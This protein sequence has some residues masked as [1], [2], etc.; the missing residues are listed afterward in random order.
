MA[1]CFR[2]PSWALPA[3]TSCSSRRV[4]FHPFT[5]THALRTRAHPVAPWRQYVRHTDGDHSHSPPI[6]QL[7]RTVWVIFRDSTSRHLWNEGGWTLSPLTPW[8]WAN[9][10]HKAVQKRRIVGVVEVPGLYAASSKDTSMASRVQKPLKAD[11]SRVAISSWKDPLPPHT[12]KL[13]AQ[14]TG[15]RVLACRRRETHS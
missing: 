14:M 11:Q 3:A 1:A 8:T 7:C 6:F 5:C 2:V 15:Q 9:C 13:H 4:S 12:S 10:W